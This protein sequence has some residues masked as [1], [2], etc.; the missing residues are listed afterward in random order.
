MAKKKAQPAAAAKINQSQTKSAQIPPKPQKQPN[1]K[2][3]A[4]KKN[5]PE[6]KKK[7][8][9]KVSAQS[10]KPIRKP[11]KAFVTRPTAA[12][13]L[14]IKERQALVS[15]LRRTGATIRQ[16]S[17]HLKQKGFKNA[18]P[19]TVFAD[20]EANLADIDAVRLK[21]TELLVTQ[22]LDKIDDWEF[23]FYAD[24][25]NGGKTLTID[26]RLRIGNFFV[27][28]QNQ[29]DRLLRISK[30]QEIRILTDADFA[31]ALGISQEQLPD[32]E[33]GS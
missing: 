21:N 32:D 20:L 2:T 24:F 26:E 4:K 6:S 12:E 29:R 9:R 27:T 19:A 25:K 15:D 7:S 13:E 8:V 14:V 1:K 18:S 30:P 10:K 31:K 11:R 33:T 3:A 17:V 5:T 16:I 23:S 28:L 22:E